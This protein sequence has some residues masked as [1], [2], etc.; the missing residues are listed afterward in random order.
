MQ[1]PQSLLHEGDGGFAVGMSLL[2]SL[3]VRKKR[4]TYHISPIIFSATFSGLTW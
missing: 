4:E 2:F 3:S 1:N